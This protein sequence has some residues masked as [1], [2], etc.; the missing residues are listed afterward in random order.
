MWKVFDS[1]DMVVGLNMDEHKAITIKD[2]I[3][4]IEVLGLDKDGEI[5]Q[6]ATFQDEET[7]QHW[8]KEQFTECNCK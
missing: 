8:L 4:F 1:G 3:M 5:I 2:N 6:I 7:A